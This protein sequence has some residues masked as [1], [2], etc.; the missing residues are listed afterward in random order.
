MPTVL[1][2]WVHPLHQIAQDLRNAGAKPGDCLRYNGPHSPTL[3]LALGPDLIHNRN[4]EPTEGRFLITPEWKL[5]EC[6]LFKMHVIA[7]EEY[8]YLCKRD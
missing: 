8:L 2:L 1:S 4:C 6:E 3:S 7:Q 5:G